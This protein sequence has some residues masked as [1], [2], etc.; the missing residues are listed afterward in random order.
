MEQV[1]PSRSL[2]SA[3]LTR[4][5]RVA[6]GLVVVSLKLLLVIDAN[7][8]VTCID[9]SAIKNIKKTAECGVSGLALAVRRTLH[10][11]MSRRWSGRSAVRQR[12]AGA[13]EETGHVRQDGALSHAQVDKGLNAGADGDNRGGVVTIV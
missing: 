5:L 12:E 11:A 7:D 13:G 9:I 4:L 3:A 10:S 2:L 6:S 8:L 1:W